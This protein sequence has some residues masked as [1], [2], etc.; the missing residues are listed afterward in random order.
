VANLQAQIGGLAA[1]AAAARSGQAALARPAVAE[2]ALLVDLLILRGEVLG[3][4]ADY[5]RAAELAQVLVRNAPHHCTSWLARARTLGT[6]HRFAE[7]LTDL[8]A[9]GRCGSDR[10]TVDAERAATLQAVGCY[11]EALVLRR[12]AAERRPD[13]A[14][15]GGLAVVEA[16]RGEVTEAERLFTEARRRYRGVS[17][18]PVASLDFRRGLMWLGERDLPTARAWFDDAVG[19]V[20]G[21]APALGHLA[22]VDA[23][24]GA[25]DAAID[26]LRSLALSSDD[27]EYAATLARVLIDAD[28][29]QE[30]EQW[31][32][33]AAA[34][35]DELV[36]RHPE[37]FIDHATHFRAPWVA[38][39]PK[40]SRAHRPCRTAS[41]RLT[42]RLPPS[43]R[44][45][46]YAQWRTATT[47]W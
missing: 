26:R 5:E 40:G 19:R 31:R 33:C 25:R 9:A 8:D 30:A 37:A 23:A 24:L 32:I 47:W 17:P 35:Y 28:H 43:T 15:L 29:P 4:I 22:E 10:T 34:R 6:F 42:D 16:E 27:P 45:A 13:F 39:G 38:I 14:T 7:A 1:R 41:F 21:Y 36:V 2:Q 11:G 3:R 20:P 12:D 44:K 46:G 18:F